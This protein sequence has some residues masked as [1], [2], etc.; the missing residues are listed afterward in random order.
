[1]ETPLDQKTIEDIKQRLI[2]TYNNP[3]EIYL[4]EPERDDVDNNILVVVDGKDIEHYDLMKAG[5]KA[6]VSVK[7]AKRVLVYTQE[8]FDEYSEDPST[9][10]Y[11]IKKYGKRIYARA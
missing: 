6:L 2:K 8:E 10:T 1:M 9:L 11:S 5:R 4:L 3:R 7:I